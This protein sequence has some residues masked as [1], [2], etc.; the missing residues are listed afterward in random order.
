MLMKYL[1]DSLQSYESRDSDALY[2]VSKEPDKSFM[3]DHVLNMPVT[4]GEFWVFTEAVMN[5][6]APSNQPQC[7][8]PT[9]TNISLSISAVISPATTAMPHSYEPFT[10]GSPQPASTEMTCIPTNSERPPLASAVSALPLRHT[11][12]PPI[13]GVSI[14]DVGKDDQSWQRAVR[15]WE[16]GDPG[17]RLL[18]LKDWPKEWYSGSQRTKTGVKCGQHRLIALEFQRSVLTSVY[19]CC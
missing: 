19:H 10:A 18:L 12:A 7:I 13:P 14:A 1:I 5:R 2:P 11:Q 16:E 17:Q 6:S 9:H 3:G 8:C 4:T 15:Q